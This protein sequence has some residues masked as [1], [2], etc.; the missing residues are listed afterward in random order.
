LS[1][2]FKI[3]AAEAF[4]LVCMIDYLMSSLCISLNGDHLLV[5]F[6]VPNASFEV[7]APTFL[8]KV[9]ESHAVMIQVRVSFLLFCR[10]PV[11][12]F[13]IHP[14]ESCM[15]IYCVTQLYATIAYMK[16]DKGCTIY[17]ENLP[18]RYQF[19][20]IHISQTSSFDYNWEVQFNFLITEAE[21][22]YYFLNL[23]N[24]FYLPG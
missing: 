17:S 22:H 3:S 20:W 13:I 16:S 24:I 6:S 12:D 7:Y 4:F 23:L 19:F 5:T 2:S 9:V 14:D 1:L 8:Q 11:F 15:C 21:G 18:L 10:L